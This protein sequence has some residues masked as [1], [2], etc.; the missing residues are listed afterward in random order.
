VIFKSIA[1]TLFLAT[2]FF[3][4]SPF[5]SVQAMNLSGDG[6]IKTLDSKNTLKAIQPLFLVSDAQN[7]SDT[8]ERDS[9]ICH[10]VT[11]QD[12][13]ASLAQEFGLTESTLRSWGPISSGSTMLIPNI[14]GLFH[15]IKSGE[16][17]GILG[18]HYG[19]LSSS[20]VEYNKGIRPQVMRVG[21]RVFI[22]GALVLYKTVSKQQLAAHNPT[23]DRSSRLG[24]SRHLDTGANS[25][26]TYAQKRSLIASRALAG[27]MSLRIG[28]FLK[29]TVGMLSSPFGPRGRG[30][31]PGMDI[32][33]HVGTTI[34][35]A[36]AGIVRSAGWNGDYGYAV[37]IDHGGG[38]IT[39]YGHC[40][41]LLVSAGQVV[42][43]R[44]PIA[45]MGSTGR[46][47]GPH[48]HFEVRVNGRAINP[49]AFL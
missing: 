3:F 43:D 49:A 31:H 28:T 10:M 24:F 15:P 13:Y 46:S 21:Y 32:C 40:S 39:R 9:M 11:P 18:E 42:N 26:L 12:S 25:K 6:S 35:A 16:T 36:R 4:S 8:V 17:L 23:L 7:V 34:T 30:F 48:V 1:T 29:P 41:R 5:H 33:N 20:L 45:L 19:M 37:D 2:G 44:Q 38:V 27:A 14:D 22:P 47:T